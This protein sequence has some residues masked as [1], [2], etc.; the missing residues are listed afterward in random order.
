[1]LAFTTLGCPDLTL[2]QSLALARRHRLDAIELRALA[3][4]LEL[5]AY[6]VRTYGT[7]EKLAARLVPEPVK[8]IAFDTSLRMIGNTPADREAFLQFVPWAEALGARWLRT[9]DGGK[10]AD[11]AE[12]AEAAATMQW[13]RELRAKH[14]W[15]SDLMV[16]THDAFVTTPAIR[17]FL[18]AAPGTPILWDTHHT[19]KKGGEDPVATWR[20]IKAHV[21]H[22]HVKDSVSVPVLKYPYTIVLPGTGEFPMQPIITVL[23]AEYQGAVSL[24]WEKVWHPYLAPLDDALAAAEKN[25]WW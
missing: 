6:L 13:W 22:V 9:F 17:R 25:R 3:G 24:E 21:V 7:P 5:P 4:T 14:G 18:A 23:R 19:W 1:M 12:V 16:E 10:T 15:K 11:A 20:A 2:E 8:V